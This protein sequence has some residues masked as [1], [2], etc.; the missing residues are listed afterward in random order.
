MNGPQFLLQNK[1][2]V[3]DWLSNT[4]LSEVQTCCFFCRVVPPEES[5]DLINV[6]FEQR[7]KNLATGQKHR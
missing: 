7:P 3:L 2:T 6:A 4:V 5:I 1:Q